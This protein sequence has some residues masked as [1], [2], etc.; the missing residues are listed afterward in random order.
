MSSLAVP[1]PDWGF[2]RADHRERS[3]RARWRADANQH[4]GGL[5]ARN[6]QEVS[7]GDHPLEPDSGGE[8]VSEE[9]LFPARSLDLGPEPGV[10]IGRRTCQPQLGGS[11]RATPRTVRANPRSS[12]ARTED[13]GAGIP[14]SSCRLRAGTEKAIVRDRST[15]P[16]SSSASS[17]R[18]LSRQMR[19]MSGRRR[20]TV[21]AEKY[22][23]VILRT[24]RCS[25]PEADARTAGSWNP[26]V[27][28]IR[29][30]A[31]TRGT[32]VVS[33]LSGTY[34]SG[35]PMTSR[36]VAGSSTRTWR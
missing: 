18:M 22:G 33:A 10:E 28:R 7:Q 17:S 34:D 31:G 11:A 24:F 9:V 27:A 21:V 35:S 25:S 16:D 3:P 14:E 15:G 36:T 32:L 29:R 8:Q 4:S 23:V 20:R 2:P 19:R 12:A 1:G 13:S 6:D 26:T 30:A 5:L